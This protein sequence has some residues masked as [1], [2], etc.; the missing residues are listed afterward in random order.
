MRL[1]RRGSKLISDGLE[2]SK[3]YVKIKLALH[4][5]LGLRPWHESVLEVD[6]DAP[7]D[8]HQFRIWKYVISLRQQLAELA[9]PRH[10]RK[11]ESEAD[12]AG[13]EPPP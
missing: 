9:Q 5:R 4:R 10:A 2:D 8:P 7:D 6:S 1:F 3:E 11:E 12:E 13:A